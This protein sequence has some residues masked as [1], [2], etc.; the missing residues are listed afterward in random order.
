MH[1]CPPP[2][3]CPRAVCC[4]DSAGQAASGADLEALKQQLAELSRL[5]GECGDNV[6]KLQTIADA[7]ESH[8]RRIE[9]LEAAAVLPAAAPPAESGAADD[10]AGAADAEQQQVQCCP[11]AR[12]PA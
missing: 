2:P 5:M 10:G 12:S 4:A 9:A 11:I 7:R 6:D 8:K 3:H 1:P